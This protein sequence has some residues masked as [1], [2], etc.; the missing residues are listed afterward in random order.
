M[1]AEATTSTGKPH[2]IIKGL[3]SII[4]PMYLTSYPLFHNTGNTIGSVKEHTDAQKTPYEIVVVDDGSPIQLPEPTMYKAEKY[5]KNP[6]NEGVTKSWNKG[7]RISQG[8]YICL[9]NNDVMVFDHW[10]EDLQECLRHKDLVA[11]TPMYGQPFARAVESKKM[12]DQYEGKMIGE[13]FS[14]FE[15]FACVLTKRDLFNELGLF[16]DRYINYVQDVDFKRRMKEAG[17]TYASTKKVAIFHIIGATGG[18]KFVCRYCKYIDSRLPETPEQMNEDKKK[19]KEKWEGGKMD[20][21]GYKPLSVAEDNLQ[22]FE[23]SQHPN[24]SPN[25]EPEAPKEYTLETLPKLIRTNETGDKIYYVENKTLHW[26]TNPK[27]ME[28]LGFNFGDEIAIPRKLFIQIKSGQPISTINV[29]QFKA[30]M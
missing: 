24:P 18:A 7:I 13:S 16:D 29:E 3:T 2:E 25:P 21:T 23:Q 19:Y 14:D 26:I 4:I 28:I 8:E 11:A 22:K 20:D 9:M 10:L 12:R 27:V 17:K 30:Q 5:T 6:E 1:I 15:D